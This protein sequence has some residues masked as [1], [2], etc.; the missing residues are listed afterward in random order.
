M[1]GVNLGKNKASP[2]ESHDDYV[3]GVKALGQFADYIVIN[4]SSPN[5]PGLRALQRREPIQQLLEQAKTA[6][7]QHVAHKPPL[8]VKIAPDCSDA[9]LEDIAAVVQQVGIDGIIISNTTVSRPPTLKSDPVLVQQAGGLSGAP[10][11][12]LALQTVRK[13]YKL[14]NGAIPIIGCGGVSSAQDALNLAKAGA[15]LVQLYTALG[16]KGPGIVRN[17]KDDL[18]TML[19]QEGKTWKDCIGLDHKR[20]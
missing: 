18:A 17:I 1:L 16:Y 6:R 2:P 5:T 11:R 8:L 9:E 12:A 14:T 13:F 4:I 3:N 10:V 15:S 7:D 20:S 19:Q